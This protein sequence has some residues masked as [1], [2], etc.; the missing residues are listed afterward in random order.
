MTPRV[1]FRPATPFDAAAVAERIRPEDRDEILTSGA[2]A[3]VRSALEYGISASAKAHV[4]VR[5]GRPLYA[6]GLIVP[7]GSPEVSIGWM[8]GTTDV[9]KCPKD[10]IRSMN[11]CLR[12]MRADAAEFG[13]KTIVNAIPESNRSYVAWAKRYIGAV[14]SSVPLTTAAGARFLEFAVGMEA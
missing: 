5:D 13:V 1:S 10:F 2:F 11:E 8:S 4:A 3:D 14:F 12:I 6:F 7:P 9:P